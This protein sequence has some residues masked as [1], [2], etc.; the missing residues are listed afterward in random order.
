[1][2]SPAPLKNVEGESWSLCLCSTP[3]VP[4]IQRPWTQIPRKVTTCTL[5]QIGHGRWGQVHD[6]P[7]RLVVWKAAL[8]SQ[9]HLGGTESLRAGALQSAGLE[10]GPG[11]VLTFYV[12]LVFSFAKWG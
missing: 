12:T 6:P 1:M 3:A 11:L 10:L 5:S 4:G 9:S 8:S 7:L 2:H